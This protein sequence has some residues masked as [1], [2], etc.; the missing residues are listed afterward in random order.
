VLLNG[1]IFAILFS[2]FSLASSRTSGVP[3]IALVTLIVLGFLFVTGMIG[4]ALA[5]MT[6]SNTSWIFNVGA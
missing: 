2:V 6:S 4:D 1:I 5:L 3:R